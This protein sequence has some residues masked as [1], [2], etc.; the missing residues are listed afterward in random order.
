MFLSQRILLVDG[1]TLVILCFV[2]LLGDCLCFGRPWS[3]YVISN[4]YL[5]AITDNFTHGLISVISTYFLF[6]WT[7]RSLFIIAFIAGSFVDCDHFIEVRSFSLHRALYDQP[8]SRPFLHNTLLLLVVT[9]IVVLGEYFLWQSH[10][11]YYSTIFFL[12]WSTHHLRDA[13]RRGLTLTPLGETS[14]I[15]YYIPIMCQALVIVKLLYMFVFPI[16]T[17]PVNLS[18]V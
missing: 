4:T 17:I 14:P 15:N 12:G 7:R 8:R 1:L 16:R 5:R 3:F 11:I 2:S 13:Q 6:G 10:Q 18:I 9:I